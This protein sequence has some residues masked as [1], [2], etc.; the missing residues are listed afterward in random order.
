[1]RSEV[2][3]AER[4]EDGWLEAES[5]WVLSDVEVAQFKRAGLRKEI[6]DRN[7]LTQVHHV[8]SPARA[9]IRGQRI[10]RREEDGW[11]LHSSGVYLPP[12]IAPDDPRLW[13]YAEAGLDREAWVRLLPRGETQVVPAFGFVPTRYLREEDGEPEYLDPQWQR[14][15][16][17]RNADDEVNSVV[18][19][20]GGLL[21]GQL[22][23]G[24]RIAAV[25]RTTL[26]LQ[27]AASAD[28]ATETDGSPLINVSVLITDNPNS[29]VGLRW[30][31]S[32]LSGATINSA[33][34]QVVPSSTA[35]DE[36][37]HTFYCE[38]SDAPAQFTTTT[39]DIS[40]RP[41]TSASMHWSSGDLGANGT[42]FFSSPEMDTEVQEAVDRPGFA[43]VLVVLF[44]GGADTN[45]DL[46]IRSYDGN[47]AQAAKLDVDY[48]EA[49]GS[50]THELAGDARSS[51]SATG[52]LSV[53]R[54][55][56]G[57]ARSSTRAE[58][59]L[60]RLVGLAAAA[61]SNTR[62]GAALAVARA[63]SA[64]ARS[65]ARVE[66]AITVA[67]SLAASARSSTRAEGLLR[68][69]R[70]LVA[71]ARSTT[72]AEGNLTIED[73]TETHELSGEARSTARAEGSLS[74]SRSLAGAARSD[75]RAAGALTLLRALAGFARSA[76]HVAANL[77]VTRSLSGEARSTTRAEGNL[78]T[79]IVAPD[80]IITVDA[81]LD[82]TGT[83]TAALDSPTVAATLDATRTLTATLE[84]S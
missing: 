56:A 13:R 50:E 27:I 36:P 9:A 55:L 31:T 12:D 75:T 38:D 19:W 15:T 84:G 30:E 3:S 51:T 23:R 33:I 52:F 82:A 22:S 2:I 48:T 63:L 6:T 81:V 29:V 77:V 66:G 32:G 41:R 21:E 35:N 5:I 40:D 17:V 24:D 7:L 26:N 69:A 62:G 74:V 61:R 72:R 79:G 58:G 46:F 71:E 10:I 57:A 49:A 25:Q 45:R 64:A 65:A 44:H 37:D 54:H 4:R 83:L 14:E 68:V 53:T 47:T 16:F 78:T 73:S 39:N 43:E 1:M 11:L 18:G 28:D 8:L 67:R 59:S 60:S 76:G 80:I 34:V 70:T 42:N 20:K